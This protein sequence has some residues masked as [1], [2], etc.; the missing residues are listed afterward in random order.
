MVQKVMRCL[1]FAFAALAL[2]L[3]F[4]AFLVPF[5]SIADDVSAV[6]VNLNM[7]LFDVLGGTNGDT[8]DMFGS[9]IAAFVLF[10]VPCVGFLRSRE[11]VRPFLYAVYLLG[12][13]FG[14]FIFNGLSTVAEAYRP[15]SGIVIGPTAGLVLTYAILVLLVFILDFAET[16]ALEPMRKLMMKAR[17]PLSIEERLA[18]LETLRQEGTISE[19]EYAEARKATLNGSKE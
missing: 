19:E 1:R 8:V 9:L 4:V 6:G 2:L 12:F 14:M 11:A 15:T 13:T 17:S 7:Y 10:L 18:E 16:F 3:L 5:V